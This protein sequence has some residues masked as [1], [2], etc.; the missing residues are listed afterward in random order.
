MDIQ[1]LLDRRAILPRLVVGSKRQVLSVI[2]EAGARLYGMNP[3]KAV[4][5]MLAREQRGSTGVG[6]G[7]AV[8]HARVA[9]LD[10]IHGVFARLEAPVAFD[11]VDEQPV[12]LVFAL[13]APE[14]P[15][16]DHLRALARIS[17]SLRQGELRSQLRQ[18]RTTDALYALLAQEERQ[19]AAA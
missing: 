8:P 19:G 12:D 2:A 14:G 15:R 11:A 4:A 3:A 5:A 18:A 13:F 7:V 9:G 17:R 1:G 16:S 6:F 10:R